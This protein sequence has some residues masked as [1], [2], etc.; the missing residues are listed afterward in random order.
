MSSPEMRRQRRLPWLN[1][2]LFGPEVPSLSGSVKNLSLKGMCISADTLFDPDIKLK[3]LI[4]VQKK[5]V[6]MEGRVCWSG[7]DLGVHDLG[8]RKDLGLEILH[9][10]GK[11]LNL[12]EN[13]IEGFQEFAHSPG[14]RHVLRVAFPTQRDLAIEYE[15]NIRHGGMFV[16]TRNPPPINTVVAL[17]L[18]LV[19][20]LKVIHAEAKVVHV[21]NTEMAELLHASPGVGVEFIRFHD[22]GQ[23]AIRDYIASLNRRL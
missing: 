20:L 14:T 13:V 22:G 7:N 1:K 12:I 2:V 17:H 6:M 21:I 8:A 11:Y 16:R 9:R 10:D 5:R 23:R 18:V 15:Q 4:P 19:D 3:V